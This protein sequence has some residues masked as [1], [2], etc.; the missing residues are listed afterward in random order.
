MSAEA[1]WIFANEFFE[2][3][4]VVDTPIPIAALFSGFHHI[5]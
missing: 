1:T 3:V 2:S 4:T 5:G